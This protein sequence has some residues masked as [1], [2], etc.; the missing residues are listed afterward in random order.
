MQSRW[1]LSWELLKVFRVIFVKMQPCPKNAIRRLNWCKHYVQS[2]S[3]DLT[4]YNPVIQLMTLSTT[5][6]NQQQTNISKMTFSLCFKWPSGIDKFNGWITHSIWELN[7]SIL[8][9]LID[10]SI[11]CPTLQL[12]WRQ[13]VIT[14]RRTTV[15]GWPKTCV[16]TLLL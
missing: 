15:R 11:S 3:F 14:L 5:N 16:T 10:L 4:I 2:L 13:I 12:P 6:E 8:S 1:S 9:G 7:Y